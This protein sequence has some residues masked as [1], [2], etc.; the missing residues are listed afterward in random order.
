M[1]SIETT[2]ILPDD[3]LEEILMRLPVKYLLRWKC[4]SKRW[5]ALI[6]EYDFAKKH[7]HFQYAMHG[8]DND[9]GPLFL[10]SPSQDSK[11]AQFYLLSKDGD[12]DVVL[13]ITS[14][15]ERDIPSPFVNDCEL[16]KQYLGCMGVMNGVIGLKWG[17]TRLA[18]WNP[19]TRE[20][21]DVPRWPVI[22]DNK[23]AEKFGGE[24]LGLVFDQQS[25][26]FKILGLI[27]FGVGGMDDPSTIYGFHL[28]SLKSNSW[29]RI[30][31]GS[32]GRPTIFYSD[33][34]AC[35]DNG[36]YYWFTDRDDLS[37][38]NV[39]LSFDFKSEN[40]KELN[41][42]K[43]YECRNNQ[44]MFDERVWCGCKFAVKIGKYREG[45]ALFVTHTFENADC[46][47]EIWAVTKFREDD[48]VLPLSWELV[49]I[50]EPIHSFNWL[51][52]VQAFRGYGDLLVVVQRGNSFEEEEACLYDP[53]T[54]TYNNLGLAFC[55][56]YKYVESLFSLSG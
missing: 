28:Y 46:S 19:A 22:P 52:Y 36:V 44:H 7:Y 5:Y 32:S 1:E 17:R 13:D 11:P 4:V 37:F 3:I 6:G 38:K 35:L 50:V 9:A 53:S 8:A 25:N 41:P 47:L 40:F 39:I 48:H 26:D 29:K 16:H 51:L 30:E 34:D 55:S 10:D 18:L 42:P 12:D 31:K 15:F 49:I 21:K 33:R 23:D 56:C 27:N 20:F 24:I 45:I 43:D 2:S 54:H 14:D